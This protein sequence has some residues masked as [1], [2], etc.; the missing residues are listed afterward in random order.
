MP[1]FSERDLI[2]QKRGG[3]I[4]PHPYRVDLPAYV[5][6]S[7]GRTSGYMLYHILQEFDFEL[8]EDLHIVFANTG[9]EREETL[10]FVRDCEE[11]WDVKINWLEYRSDPSKPLLMPGTEHHKYPDIGCHSLAEVNYATASRNGEPYEEFIK[12]KARWRM[13]IKDED[14]IL[15]NVANRWC[16]FGLKIA[17]MDRWMKDW[18][19][20]EAFDAIVGLRADEP[21][22]VR[23]LKAGATQFKDFACPMDDAIVTLEEV[24]EFW[25]HQEFDLKLK[26]DPDLGTYEGN[27][28]LCFLKNSKK[29]ARLIE[30]NPESVNWWAEMEEKY[31]AT[32]WRNR[33][34]FR[35]LRDDKSARVA[36]KMC[37]DEDGDTCACTL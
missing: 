31:G 36:L 34:T 32:F 4:P 29:I 25:R 20:Y 24:L 22:R 16:S 19:G 23:K 14:P 8:P 28:D 35:Q 26:H 37:N 18:M 33:P 17:T 2:L 1:F 27:C 15:P 5:S 13:E 21:S 9:K 6:F 7:G 12:V 11:R 3:K 30:E 10:E